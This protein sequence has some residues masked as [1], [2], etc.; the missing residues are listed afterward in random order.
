MDRSNWTDRTYYFDTNANIV[1]ANSGVA[2]LPANYFRICNIGLNGDNFYIEDLRLPPSGTLNHGFYSTD[3]IGISR[4]TWQDPYFRVFSSGRCPYSY[5]QAGVKYTSDGNDTLSLYDDFDPNIDYAQWAVYYD[6]GTL[7][8]ISG[9]LANTPIISNIIGSGLLVDCF[10]WFIE[11]YSFAVTPPFV[12]YG[13]SCRNS[14]RNP[15]WITGSGTTYNLVTSEYP[16]DQEE[17]IA[18]VTYL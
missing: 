2:R 5:W 9:D 1:Y 4:P 12:L 10:K 8:A 7:H 13:R 15:N 6:G 17:I 18:T 3:K 16:Y 14:C 11:P